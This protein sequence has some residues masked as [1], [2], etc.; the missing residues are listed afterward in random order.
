MTPADSLLLTQSLKLE[1]TLD[2]H[3]GC[4]NSICWNHNGTK[5]LSGSDDQKLVLTDPFSNKVLV[6]YTTFHRNNIFSAKFLPQS[7]TRIVSC[8]G[9]GSV[10]YTD[11]N[12]INFTTEPDSDTLVGGNY[13]ASNQDANFF[14]CHS[15]TC[16][17]VLTIPSEL[18]SFMSCGEDGSVRYFDM[19][20]VSKCH[21]QYCR[22]NILILNSSS[23]TA[24]SC[25]PISNNYLSI[26]CSD[27]L[28]RVYDRRFLKLV[29]IPTVSEGTPP[30]LSSLSA[31]YQT[32][33]VKIYKIPNDQKRSYRITSVNYSKDERELL[34]SYSSEYLYLFDMTSNGVAKELLP[35]T[36]RRRRNR[37]SPRILRKLR[38]RGDWSDTGPY[39]LPSNEASAQSRPQLN[40]SIMNRMTGL[41][42]RMLNDN[43]SRH[44]RNRSNV[45]EGISML[46]NE[47]D[48][49]D[50]EGSASNSNNPSDSPP[51]PPQ[52]DSSS[53]SS[54]SS[55]E[56]IIPVDKYSYV[57]QKYIGHRNART[58]IKEANFWGDDYVSDK[59]LVPNG[60]LIDFIFRFF[61]GLTVDTFSCGTGKQ[62]NLLIC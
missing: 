31:E 59:K 46:L 14:N 12:D 32:E 56:D 19:R 60:F 51:S 15:G 47:H 36:T 24:M 33:P 42:S 44:N 2:I 27:S 49:I 8:S 21:K 11:L 28:I 39:S 40:S 58:M 52:E 45:V 7:D 9:A 6:R 17:E 16:Y 38:L 13:R 29:E 62:P 3:K 41:L 20:L 43:S 48:V 1:K 53:S 22:E 18:N 61:R 25:S 4:V 35:T 5:I 37:E 57:R 54:Y 26:G 55:D 10:L 34:V 50:A 23:V 30:S